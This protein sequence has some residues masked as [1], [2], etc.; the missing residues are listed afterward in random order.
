M[1]RTVLVVEDE[2]DIL[3]GERI[4]LEVAGYR[5][6]TAASAEE[7]LITLEREVPDLLVLDLRLPGMDGW[8]LLGRLKDMGLLPGLAVIVAS[9]DA[10]IE[11]ES[12]AKALGCRAYLTKPFSVEDLRRTVDVI[13]S[14]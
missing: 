4:A 2:A 1:T 11:G 9:A 5:V 12:Q 14:D 10:S 3:L 8:G 7:A 6:L 13:L